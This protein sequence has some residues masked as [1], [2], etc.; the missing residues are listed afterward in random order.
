MDNVRESREFLT[1]KKKLFC[2]DDF[3]TE[4]GGVCLKNLGVIEGRSSSASLANP[5]RVSRTGHNRK[6]ILHTVSPRFNSHHS[7]RI[8]FREKHV[9]GIYHR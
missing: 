6:Q 8:A 9:N 4:R 3:E 2:G 5:L 1:F 7:F